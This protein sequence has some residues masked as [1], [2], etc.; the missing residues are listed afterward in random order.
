M[1]VDRLLLL[2]AIFCQVCLAID[3]DQKKIFEHVLYENIK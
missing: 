3:V 1:K 2:I